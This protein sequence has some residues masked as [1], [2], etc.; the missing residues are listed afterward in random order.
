MFGN[1]S[2]KY[3]VPVHSYSLRA[4][5]TIQQKA[6]CTTVRQKSRDVQCLAIPHMHWH[7]I[8]E[9]TA[10]QV[11]LVLPC[12]LAARPATSTFQ[13]A[14]NNA[15]TLERYMYKRLF[16]KQKTLCLRNDCSR[17]GGCS[18]LALSLRGCYLLS[19]C[20]F[21]SLSSR[22]LCRACLLLWL[23]GCSRLADLCLGCLLGRRLACFFD[24]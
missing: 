22:L 23:A 10:K 6:D 3:A 24:T 18:L 9:Q 8:Q 21:C 13:A 14:V 1:S 4:A 20:S 19:G 12:C 7:V 2:E 17:F 16:A 5:L 15:R 11:L